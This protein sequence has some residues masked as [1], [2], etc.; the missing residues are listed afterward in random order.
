M[1]VKYKN[2][3][4]LVKM[5]K[6]SNQLKMAIGDYCKEYNNKNTPS[7]KSITLYKPSNKSITLYKPSNKSM[8]LYTPPIKV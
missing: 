1:V 4:E 5:A 7:N 8:I 2:L 6:Q 3:Q